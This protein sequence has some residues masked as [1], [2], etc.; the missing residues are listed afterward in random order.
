MD[1]SCLYIIDVSANI[2]SNYFSALTRNSPRYSPDDCTLATHYYEAIELTVSNSG[3]HT[4]VS[5]SSI[6]IVVY[7]YIHYFNISNPNANWLMHHHISENNTQSNFTVRLET[8][9][10]YVLVVSTYVPNE[11]GTFSIMVSGVNKVN[12][13]RMSK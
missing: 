8:A 6:N 13:S 11:I 2:Q 3:C 9:N 12:L 7:I 4:F 1:C 5:T 10:K